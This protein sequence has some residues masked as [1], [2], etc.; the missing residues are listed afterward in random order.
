MLNKI[1]LNGIKYVKI[2]VWLI[3]VVEIGGRWF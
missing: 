3:G 1:G 2:F